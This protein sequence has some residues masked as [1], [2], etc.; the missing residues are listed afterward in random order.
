MRVE[1][2]QFSHGSSLV[3]V[4]LFFVFVSEGV[5]VI[6]ALGAASIGFGLSLFLR[7]PEES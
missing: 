7:R 3:A 2:V 4:I 5:D 6:A 1:R